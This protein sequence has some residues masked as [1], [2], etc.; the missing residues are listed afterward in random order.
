MD[1]PRN[2]GKT[3]FGQPQDPAILVSLLVG[4]GQLTLD[5]FNAQTGVALGTSSFAEARYG[6]SS[7]GSGVGLYRFDSLAQN[8]ENLTDGSSLIG[9]AWSGVAVTPAGSTVAEAVTPALTSLAGP[10]CSEPEQHT[11]DV[12]SQSRWYASDVSIAYLQGKG[13]GR[14]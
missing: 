8:R 12:L 14:K 11:V 10:E 9:Q 1:C 6:F 4:N 3:T 7:G 5:V 2:R 13:G